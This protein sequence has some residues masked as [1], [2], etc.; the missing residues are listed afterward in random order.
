[1]SRELAELFKQHKE[2]A[3]RGYAKLTGIGADGKEIAPANVDEALA[4]FQQGSI[5][6]RDVVKILTGGQPVQPPKH[7][8]PVFK[9]NEPIETN[10]TR[11]K[12]K[13]NGR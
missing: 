9:W 5:G 10:G 2:L 13:R 12:A 4:L 1:M 3:R 8:E 11:R 6:A 7:V